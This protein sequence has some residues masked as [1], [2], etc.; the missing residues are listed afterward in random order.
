MIAFPLIVRNSIRRLLQ[1]CRNSNNGDTVTDMK[2]TVNG[3][4]IVELLIVIVVIAILAT[5]SVVAYN[6]IQQRARTSAHQHAASQAEREIMVHALQ[7]NGE[8]ISLNGTLVG[9]KEGVGDIQLLKPLTGTP[10]ITMYGVYAVISAAGHYPP[11][12]QLTPETLG[13]HAFRLQTGTSGSMEMGYR[14]DTPAHSNASNHS[15]GNRSPGNTV[16]GWVQVNSGATVRTYGYNA[17]A[18]AVTQSLT[19]GVGWNFTGVS[20]TATG[21]GTPRTVLVFNTAHD[22]AT[23]AQVMSWLAQ[24]Y[25]V[26]L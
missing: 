22:Q 4:T 13:S 1:A 16:I 23:R 5:I 14:I 3:F 10:D 19:P 2:K 7:V 9:Y 21:D 26:S 17:A 11:F 24:K 25:G 8:S 12:V 15:N 6:G 18:S 20:L